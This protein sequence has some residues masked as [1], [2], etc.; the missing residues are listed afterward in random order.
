ML[1]YE[2]QLVTCMLMLHF[3]FVCY[4]TVM[5]DILNRGM[6]EAQGSIMALSRGSMKVYHCQYCPK[7]EPTPA[8]LMVHERVHTGEKPFTCEVCGKTF[9]NKSNMTKHEVVHRKLTGL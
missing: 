7:T 8:K 9:A 2:Y 6:K 3:K 4:I 1:V 5:H